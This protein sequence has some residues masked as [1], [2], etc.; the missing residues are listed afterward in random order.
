MYRIFYA[1]RDTTLYE[2]YP[3]QNTGIDQ[4]L[5]L[6]KIASGSKLNGIRQ[7]NQ[8]NSRFL[9][10][11]GSEITTLSSSITTGDIPNIA[12]HALSSSVYLNLRASDASDLLHSYE[13]KAFPISESWVN[14]NGNFSDEPIT[15]NGASWYYSDNDDV[16]TKW[17]TGSALSGNTSA[18]TT[19]TAGG[20]TWITGSGYEASQS[21]QNQSP[22]IRMNV[23]DIVQKWLEQSASNNGF[24]IKR[25]Y[26]NEISGEVL[27]N[28]KFFGRE[29]H[30]IFV[31]R[32]E[33][34]WNDTTFTNTSS[35]EISSDV[36]VPYFKNIK[37]EY[38]RTGIAKFRIGVRP[39]FPE[40]AYQ[41]ESFY[42]TGERLPTSSFYSI[43]DSVTDET[44][45]PFDT[46]SSKIDCDVNGSFFKLRMDSFMP[47]RFYKIMLKIERD[48]GNDIQTFDDFY[49]KVVK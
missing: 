35:T 33:V 39:E 43:I 9:I 34:V 16:Q 46:V 3:E 37:A 47:E 48:A 6:T 5:E 22:D 15:K 4:I 1:E 13:I 32:L 21:F 8:Y 30:T 38:R 26:V 23:S 7:T 11:F 40:K 29:S 27:G 36:Y 2:K 49:F 45:I 25:P 17:N 14:G 24:I 10:D 19:E 28:L 31:P 42:L 41:T 20:G 44:I 18:G 12:N